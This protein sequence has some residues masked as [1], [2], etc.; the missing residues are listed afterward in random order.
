MSLL[1]IA[2]IVLTLVVFQALLLAAAAMVWV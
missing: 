1:L 2:Q